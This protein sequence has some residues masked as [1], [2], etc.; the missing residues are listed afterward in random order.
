MKLDNSPALGKCPIAK[1]DC[2]V[3][4]KYV[5]PCMGP[6][7]PDLSSVEPYLG[8]ALGVVGIKKN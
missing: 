4:P 8:H 3:I 1:P 2:P 5:T 7:C 6:L